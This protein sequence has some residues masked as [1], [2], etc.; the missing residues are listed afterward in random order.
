MNVSSFKETGHEEND[1]IT[2]ELN[3][4]C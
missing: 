1:A 3:I 2:E 4:F